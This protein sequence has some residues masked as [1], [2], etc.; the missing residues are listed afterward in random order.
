[1]VKCLR[2][3][4]ELKDAV[5]HSFDRYGKDDALQQGDGMIVTR[6]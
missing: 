2:G 4:S 3:R 6:G 5:W 1:M